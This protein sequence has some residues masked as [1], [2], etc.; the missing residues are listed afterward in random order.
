[1]CL[2]LAQNICFQFLHTACMYVVESNDLPVFISS[3]FLKQLTKN[4]ED[5]PDKNHQ[6]H[7]QVALRINSWGGKKLRAGDTVCYV[8]CDVGSTFLCDYICWRVLLCEYFQ[9]FFIVGFFT[10]ACNLFILFVVCHCVVY[11]VFVVICCYFFRCVFN[12]IF[13]HISFSLKSFTSKWN[14]ASFRS[15]NKLE[16]C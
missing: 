9:F 7:V 5:Y 3:C 16:L 2:P 1:M 8:I 15:A 6:S 10:P 13:V 11:V 12:S 14:W 4:P